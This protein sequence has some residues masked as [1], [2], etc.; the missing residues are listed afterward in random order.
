MEF[1]ARA[2]NLSLPLGLADARSLPSQLSKSLP[3]LA[4]N[5]EGTA[6]NAAANMRAVMWRIWG[7]RIG[8]AAV[9][10]AAAGIGAALYTYHQPAGNWLEQKVAEATGA[11]VAKVVVE[12]ATY[13]DKNVLQAALGLTKGD[14]LVTFNTSAARTRLEALPWVRL[15]AV[16][17]QLPDTVRVDVYEHVPLARVDINGE[18]WVI[19][20]DGEPIELESEQFARLPMLEG[21]GAATAAARLFGVLAEWPNLTGQLAR[22]SYIGQRRWDVTFMSG[23]TVRLP[24]E[25]PQEALQTLAKLEDARHVLSLNA[26][27]VDLRVPG[28]IV[29]RL[30]AE[31]QKTPVTNS[32]EQQG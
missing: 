5:A 30:P 15:A 9:L 8:R 20:K 14:S 16:E 32:T 11:R 24:E 31:V 26:G 17:R 2:K 6:A 28:R 19:N 1:K 22:A 23:V 4:G 29:L 27:E 25:A 3:K 13:T 10:L 12:G 18:I 21:Q 7:G